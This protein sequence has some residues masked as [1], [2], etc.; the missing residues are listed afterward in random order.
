MALALGR[1][2]GHT[3]CKKKEGMNDSCRVIDFCSEIIKVVLI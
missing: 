1:R 3:H 2:T